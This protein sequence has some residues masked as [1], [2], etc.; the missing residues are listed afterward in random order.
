MGT[1]TLAIP[2]RPPVL[3][4]RPARAAAPQTAEAQNKM[5]Y[6]TLAGLFTPVMPPFYR[7]FMSGLLPGGRTV[8]PWPWAPGL[9]ALVTP[10]FF[11]FLVGPSRP[12]RRRDGAP[13]GLLV[14]KCKFLQESGCKG[15]CVNQCKLPAQQFFA[16]ALGMP[17]AVSPN[18]ETQECQWS[19]GEAPRPVA[20]DP[21]LP[22]GCL[23][24]CPTRHGLAAARE[25]R[26]CV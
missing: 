16:S 19:F 5:V 1:R 11:G 7:T 10:P 17:L 6:N 23:A 2:A 25:A 18:F 22:P 24:G 8:G 15:L 9:T 26:A 4:A 13:G 20:E 3:R 12:N 14:E 21:A